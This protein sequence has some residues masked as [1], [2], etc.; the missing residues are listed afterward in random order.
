MGCSSK[1]SCSSCN[2][3]LMT[4]HQCGNSENKFTRKRILIICTGNSCR[5]QM[6]EGWLQ[7]FDERLE[8]YSAGTR[9]EKKINAFAVNVM[10]EVGIDISFHYPKSIEKY[11]NNSFDYVITVCDNAKQIC[12]SFT[13]EVKNRLHIGFED[14]ADA[15]GSDEE[16]TEVYRRVRDQI[17]DE[18]YKFFINL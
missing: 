14:P 2:E 18:F 4:E 3:D 1:G 17:R 12:P 7:S 11:V 8:I 5:S 13:A 15:N 6:A 9:P 10:A 16:I